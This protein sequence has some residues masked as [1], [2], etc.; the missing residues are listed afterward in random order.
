MKIHINNPSKLLVYILTIF[1]MGSSLGSCNVGT[2]EPESTNLGLEYFPLEE[3]Q[4]IDYQVEDIQ[5]TILNPPDTSRYQLRELIGEEFI[6]IEG[7]PAFRLE[8]YRRADANAPWALDSIWQIKRSTTQAIVIQNNQP[9]IKLVFPLGEG[10]EWVGTAFF[11]V[12][13]TDTIIDPVTSDTT[14]QE[15]FIGDRYRVENFNKPLTFGDFS[16]DSTLTVI[17]SDDS[18]RI[19]IDRRREIYAA[20][21]GLI[22]KDGIVATYCTP[23]E[24]CPFPEIE[25][26]KKTTQTIIGFGKL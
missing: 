9:L 16:F 5:Y 24:S 2:L 15:T 14:I 22:Y 8:R 20:N 10:V 19:S 1:V 17:Q 6:D 21:R 11:R 3:G 25:F 26:G 23:S 7:N 4:Y 13:R 12:N 18:S